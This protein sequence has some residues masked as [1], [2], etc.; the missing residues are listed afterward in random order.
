MLGEHSDLIGL[1]NAGAGNEGIA[2]ALEASGRAQDIVWIAH[3]L[4]ADT[5]RFLLGG[6]VDA[7]INQIPGTKPAPR[8]ESCLPL[9]RRIDQSR[10][11]AHPHRNLSQRQFAVSC[12][13]VQL[14]ALASIAQLTAPTRPDLR[15]FRD[16]HRR[17]SVS[18]EK[19]RRMPKGT[20]KETAR[21]SDS[22]AAS[23]AR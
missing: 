12:A 16:T 5:R 18:Q 17:R 13:A 20:D 6:V 8:P 23:M 4:T 9:L 22:V 2:G 3:E 1:Y 7:I 21:N 19:L 11:G 15:T 14:K 10:S